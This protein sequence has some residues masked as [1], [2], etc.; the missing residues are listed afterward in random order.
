[1]KRAVFGLIALLAVAA[2]ARAQLTSDATAAPYRSVTFGD[3]TTQVQASGARGFTALVNIGVGFEHD[4]F[5]GAGAGLAGLN[6]GIGGF[7]TPNVAILFRFSGTSVEF[8]DTVVSQTS[9]VIGAT[10]QIWVTSRWA[11]EVGGG[12]GSWTDSDGLSDGSGGL[13]LGV[14]TV[15][16]ERGSHHLTLGAEYAPVFTENMVH[17]I[18]V[19]FGYQFFRRR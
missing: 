5:Y 9:G 17:N 16:F 19:M 1:V 7:V 2:P 11:I 12:F 13:I 8:A 10:V 15:V 6:F 4:A 18:G 14:S 3:A